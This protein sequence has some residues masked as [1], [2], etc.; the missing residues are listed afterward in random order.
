MRVDDLGISQHFVLVWNFF[1]QSVCL[2]RNSNC[3]KYYSE[4]SSQCSHFGTILPSISYAPYYNLCYYIA[5]YYV[6]NSTWACRRKRYICTL[7]WGGG[8]EVGGGGVGRRHPTFTFF[9]S[10]SLP[11]LGLSKNPHYHPITIKLL[12]DLAQSFTHF[13]HVFSLQKMSGSCE[14][15]EIFTKVINSEYL[16]IIVIN[17]FS[18]FD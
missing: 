6:K 2:K 18:R 11:K 12:T 17:L 1:F 15:F 7:S 4:H 3:S 5:R 10:F 9:A 14:A 16:V 13:S 8:G